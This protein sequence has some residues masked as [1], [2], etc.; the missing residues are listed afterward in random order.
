M[1]LFG[2]MIRI[3]SN[4]DNFNFLDGRGLETIE[5]QLFG[6]VDLDYWRRVPFFL[7][8]IIAWRICKCFGRL[9]LW[10]MTQEAWPSFQVGGWMH[11]M[12]RRG[13]PTWLDLR[14]G[15]ICDSWYFWYYKIWAVRLQ[16]VLES[17][18]KLAN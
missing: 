10:W 14:N 6:R 3:L 4:N 7:T 13:C 1:G 17:F 15:K 12:L 8:H 9:I 2:L 16:I 18:Y 5:Y 11:H